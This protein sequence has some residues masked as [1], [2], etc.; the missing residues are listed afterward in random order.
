MSSNTTLIRCRPVGRS[1]PSV[2][3]G[4]CSTAFAVLPVSS[5]MMWK[6]YH[7]IRVVIFPGGAIQDYPAAK[8]PKTKRT[9]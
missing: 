9:T 4:V 8:D 1:N 6:Q 7:L 3:C 2:I 5:N